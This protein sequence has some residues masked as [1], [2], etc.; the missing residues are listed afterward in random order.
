MRCS[1]INRNKLC[2]ATETTAYVRNVKTHEWIED[3]YYFLAL[4]GDYDG[5]IEE[6][7]YDEEKEQITDISRRR[8]RWVSKS[9]WESYTP[10]EEVARFIERT[11]ITYEDLYV[12][13]SFRNVND[14]FRAMP[15]L[16]EGA[17]GS[18]KYLE[19]LLSG[20]TATC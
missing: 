7:E 20:T 18:E 14:M 16:I 9:V 3:Y 4:T 10:S 5:L 13:D 12:A 2:Y 11:G 15:D 6:I 1:L 8:G 19:D 17:P